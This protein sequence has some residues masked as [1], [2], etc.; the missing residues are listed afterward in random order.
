MHPFINF[1]GLTIPSY[2]LMMIVAAVVAWLA[3]FAL[4]KSKGQ[5][6]AADAAYVYLI[7][8]CGGA[9]GAVT[10]RPVMKVFEV[11]ARWESYKV[12]PIGEVFGY[13]F[14]EIVFYGGLIGG[15][16]AVLL[17]C[18]AFKMR[19]VPV[20]DLLA[21]GLVI[22]HA[23][24]RIGCFLGGCCYGM[25]VPRG[26]MFSVIYPSSSLSAPAGIPLIAVPLIESAFLFL[27]FI[28]LSFIYLNVKKD[29][30]TSFVYLLLYAPGRFMLEFFRGDL[31]RGQ[32]GVFTTSQYIS[33][34]L[35][36]FAFIYIILV[37]RR[38]RTAG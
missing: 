29:G 34:G 25:Q 38:L 16:F 37:H 15:L 31:I 26:S 17:F 27:I 6:G 35:F 8:I 32:Y 10:I 30:F 9:A 13:V 24:G 23:V 36:V 4:S 1:L 14:G 7:G 2:G 33:I 21:P 18:K 20:L 22:A 5:T 19:I 3:L 11:A 12:I 28:V